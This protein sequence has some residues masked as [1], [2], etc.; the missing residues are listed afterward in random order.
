MERLSRRCLLFL[1]RSFELSPQTCQLHFLIFLGCRFLGSLLFLFCC[2]LSVFRIL[3]LSAQRCQLRFLIFGS[4]P[5]LEPGSSRELGGVLFLLA[6][7]GLRESGRHARN[8][9]HFRPQFGSELVV[10]LL[11][12]LVAEL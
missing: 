4:L 12:A 6:L 7:G 11:Q 2:L 1:V 9:V 8:L 5:L 3:E 10:E